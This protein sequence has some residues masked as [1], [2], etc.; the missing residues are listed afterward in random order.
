M[1]FEPSTEQKDIRAAAREFAE[2]EFSDVAREY[3][4]M[5]EYPKELWKKACELGF[6]GMFLDEKYDG[7]GLGF[8]EAAIVMEEF[9][10]VDAGCG[11]V[12]LAAFGSEVIRKFGSEEQ[13]EKYLPLITTGKSIM[14]TAV[15]EPDAG[16]DIF[17]V[18]TSAKKSGDEYVLNG[19]KI[20]ITNGSV[21]DF[22]LVFC[23]TSPDA[24]DRL[25]RHGFF[26]VE[27][28]RK[29]FQATKLTGKMGIRAS[30][31]AEL[32]FNDVRIPAGNL[33]GGKEGDGFRQ[34]MYLFN[35]NRVTAA[36]QG[37]GIAQGA[38][39]KAVR[40]IKQRVQFGK[41]LS[42]FQGIEFKIAEMITD[43]EVA[44]NMVYKACWHLDRG[45]MDPLVISVAKLFAGEM[46]TRVTN[47]AL[48]LHGGYGYMRDYD[49]ERF[50]RDA[51]IVEIYEGTKEIEKITI[52]GRALGKK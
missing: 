40:H 9:S 13:K 26:V 16:S 25:S 29:G 22:I 51:K 11:T 39:D 10:R 35:I 46:V 21:A 3:D 19:S 33:I 23:V 20:F 31:T 8:T 18:L 27:T 37:V 24:T 7:T 32:A 2:K 1:D 45:K 49:V 34:M 5:E 47:N 42:S 43:I 17:G 38:F 36:A 14:G 52:A 44:R 28:D 4:A 30:D 50:Y 48:Q 12:L 41:T 6:V 15:T